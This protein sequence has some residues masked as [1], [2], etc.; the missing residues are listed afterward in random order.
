MFFFFD[1]NEYNDG[2]PVYEQM[3][4]PILAALMELGGKG[5][6]AE[7]DRKA[8]E[9]MN[10]PEDI[11]KIMHKGST[12]RSEV[13]YRMAW[14]RTYL[15]NFGLIE[16]KKRGFWSVTE[17]FD[18]DIEN[19][20]PS[21]IVRKLQNEKEQANKGA[22]NL[23]F[24]SAKAFENLSISLLKDIT[25]SEGKRISINTITNESQYDLCLPDGIDDYNGHL[26][27]VI[28]FEA[29][30]KSYS[31]S[32]LQKYC[33]EHRARLKDQRLLLITNLIIPEDFRNKYRDVIVFWDK[34]DLEE[35]IDP[36][37]TYA[38]YLINPKKTF[39]EEIVSSDVSREEKNIEKENY[40]KRVT[41]AFKSGDM[42]LFL[43]AGI[44]IDGGIPL[45]DSLIKQLHIHMI[46]RLNKDWPLNAK[47]QEIMNE[48]A[49][50]NEM[51]S[52]LLQMRYI[53]S[54]FSNDE[55][56][57]LVHSVLYGRQ[58]NIDTK[59]LS[60]IA[61]ICTPQMSYCGVKNIITYNFDDLLE[62]KFDE[63]DIRYNDIS[64]EEDRQV[65]DKLNIYHVHGYLP[66]DF[67]KLKREPEL[68]FSEEDYHRV[69]RDAYSWSN[70]IQLNALRE[71]TCLFIGCSLTDPNLRRLLDV[72][73]RKEEM[74][75]HFAIL[76]R[77]EIKNNN[78]VSKSDR[79]LLEIYQRI[80]NNIQVG[81]YQELGLNIIW[82]DDYSEIPEILERIIE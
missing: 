77:N 31:L 24:Q 47:E 5:T 54:A 45:W 20:D 64:C 9:L 21:E 29:E 28:K 14:A 34:Q 60:A 44:S 79:E 81:Y 48:L 22:R 36:E 55:Y 18:G 65:V 27:C 67:K 69:Y 4:K 43:G 61:K 10:L 11:L 26:N 71:N 8:S 49:F 16:N 72:A 80:D 66:N 19:I 78:L 68:I 59:L 75:R 2:I 3:M 42:V 50:N 23:E 73:T 53:K 35:R 63:R 51:D 6:V 32:T 33:E 82:I 58:T 52:P 76:K 41:I 74:P 12:T 30:E 15:K 46:K 25:L 13:A 56:Y 17:N 38:G 62:R 37:A 40:I 1:V 7:I 70:L 39:I 57:K